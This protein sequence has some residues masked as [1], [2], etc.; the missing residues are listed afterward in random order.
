LG[1]LIEEEK[2]GRRVLRSES[3]KKM[4]ERDREVVNREEIVR[5]M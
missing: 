1:Q 4:N 5:K 2:R 3:K